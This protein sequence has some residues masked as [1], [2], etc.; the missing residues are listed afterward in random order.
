MSLFLFISH[1]V[2]RV[3][4]DEDETS[5]E[6]LVCLYFLYSQHKCLSVSIYKP[7]LIKGMEPGCFCLLVLRSEEKSGD[8]NKRV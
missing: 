1:N 3:K 4:G 6:Y 2:Q 8:G 5:L 7:Y